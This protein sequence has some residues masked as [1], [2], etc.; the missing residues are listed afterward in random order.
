MRR[1]SQV[2]STVSTGLELCALRPWFEL[3]L[4]Q[5]PA[6]E[7]SALWHWM[8]DCLDANSVGEPVA[9][10]LWDL[11]SAAP[12]NVEDLCLYYA[13]KSKCGSQYAMQL[14]SLV[15]S[16][17]VTA[18][19]RPV[20]TSVWAF[21][22]ADRSVQKNGGGARRWPCYVSSRGWFFDCEGDVFVASRSHGVI[23][24]GCVKGSAE[25]KAD[26]WPVWKAIQL[27]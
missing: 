3:V 22:V 25:Y 2:L 11:T 13:E 14:F 6:G 18:A 5:V 12:D 9:N 8:R 27:L 19:E 10:Q 7:R 15:G 1:A 17:F 23:H 26:H 20:D 21:C 16:I 24:L 4:R